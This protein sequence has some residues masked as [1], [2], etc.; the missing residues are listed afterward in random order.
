MKHKGFTLIELLIVIV[1]IG[2]LSTMILMSSTEA[3]TSSR[4]SNIVSNLRNVKAAALALYSDS[5]DTFI[6]NPNA[7]VTISDVIPYLQSGTKLPD[8]DNFNIKNFSGRWFVF[9]HVGADKADKDRLSTKISGRAESIGL[10]GFESIPNEALP[11]NLVYY[12][13][14]EYVALQIR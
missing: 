8:K 10:F 9:Y 5:I 4:A 2:V 1:V 12:K 7:K 14:G 6:A 11:N 3:V 13:K